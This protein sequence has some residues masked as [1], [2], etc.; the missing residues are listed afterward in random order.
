MS[1]ESELIPHSKLITQNSQP[2]SL[3]R[4]YRRCGRAF[5]TG[6]VQEQMI[7]DRLDLL[8]RVSSKLREHA[9]RILVEERR[10]FRA[11]EDLLWIRQPL[12]DPLGTQALACESEIR[13]QVGGILARRYYVARRM[14]VRALR[15]FEQ[16]GSNGH[17]FGVGLN[18][19]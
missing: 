10:H 5:P 14:A 7:A 2:A 16:L 11:G 19:R 15:C 1:S 9:G 8:S 4:R 17:Q 6:N 13:C 12:Q 3:V 18:L